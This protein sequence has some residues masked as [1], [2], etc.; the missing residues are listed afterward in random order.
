M[1][2]E[3]KN[4][5]NAAGGKLKKKHISK[6]FYCFF[7]SKQQTANISRHGNG[8]MCSINIWEFP[9]IGVLPNHPF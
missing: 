1:D 4:T 2:D 8:W 7:R 3:S 5:T 9:K 6:L